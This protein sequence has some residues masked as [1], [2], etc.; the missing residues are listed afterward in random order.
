MIRRPA[1]EHDSA[2]HAPGW[3]PKRSRAVSAGFTSNLSLEFP[4]FPQNPVQ[5][6]WKSRKS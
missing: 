4:S 1:C 3:A 2:Y 5:N 6:R